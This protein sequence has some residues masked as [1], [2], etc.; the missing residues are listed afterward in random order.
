MPWNSVFLSSGDAYVGELLELHKGVEYQFEFQESTWYIFRDAAVG[1]GLHV[2]HSL[3]QAS[4][5]SKNIITRSNKYLV[6]DNP[7]RL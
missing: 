7:L 6:L 4:D 2:K 1:K 3:A 5:G